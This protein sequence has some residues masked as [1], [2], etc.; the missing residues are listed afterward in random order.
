MSQ[1]T[2]ILAHMKKGRAITPLEALDLF[3][4]FRLAARVRDLRDEG[5]SIH[6]EEVELPNGKRIARYSLVA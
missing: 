6:T 1:A 2:D 5:H 4:C 3:G